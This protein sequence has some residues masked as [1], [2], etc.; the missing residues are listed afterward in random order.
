[1]AGIGLVNHYRQL[2]PDETDRCG[3]LA[4][5]ILA[6]MGFMVMRAVL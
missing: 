2:A 3:P 6:S 1:M 4:T 5:V